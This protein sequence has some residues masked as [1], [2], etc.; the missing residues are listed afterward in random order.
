MSQRTRHT[1]RMDRRNFLTAVAGGAATWAALNQVAGAQVAGPTV[2]TSAGK[3]RGQ[4]RM[5]IHSF[6]GIPYGT[7]TAGAKRFMAPVKAAPWTGVREAVRYG[8][9]SPQNMRFTEVLAP[10]ADPAEGFDEDCLNLNVWTPGI[11]DGRKRPVMFW[12]HGGGFAQ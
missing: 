1:G 10:Q 7:S 6:K 11:N 9:Q 3:V 4:T 8:H 12:C 5:G 2:E